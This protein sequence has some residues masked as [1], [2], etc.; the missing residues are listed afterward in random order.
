MILL[1]DDLPW[2]S[3]LR[4]ECH[5]ICAPTSCETPRFDSKSRTIT[6]Y[7]RQLHAGYT[8]MPR[9]NYPPEPEGSRRSRTRRWLWARNHRR[10][11]A[12]SIVEWVALLFH[13]VSGWLRMR[14]LSIDTS[15]TPRPTRI[16]ASTDARTI[17]RVY[18]YSRIALSSFAQISII[19]VSNMDLGF[20]VKFI[21][22]YPGQTGLH[23]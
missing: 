13:R 19:R 3:S 22:D 8:D 5:N 6:L 20:H 18:R 14:R 21:S 12:L 11:G 17:S 16:A 7:A 9:I 15:S 4:W 2:A 10:I 23:C 1:A